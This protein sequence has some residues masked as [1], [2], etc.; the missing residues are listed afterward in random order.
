E[1][2][3]NNKLMK[4][5]KTLIYDFTDVLNPFVADIITDEH[6]VFP[7][8]HKEEIII[9]QN[10]IETKTEQNIIKIFQPVFVELVAS[11][12]QYENK[13]VFF[14]DVKQQ[15]FMEIIFENE[16][17]YIISEETVDGKFYFDLTKIEQ[18][19]SETKFNIL[20]NENRKIIHK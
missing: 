15:S 14:N 18:P 2:N 19:P 1:F 12:I 5:E 17:K 13:N 4:R 3:V 6:V 9:E 11:E 8:T 20:S 16:N 10:V 7:V